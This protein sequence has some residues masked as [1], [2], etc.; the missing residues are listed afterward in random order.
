MSEQEY[1][2]R[3]NAILDDMSE[4]QREIEKITLDYVKTNGTIRNYSDLAQPYGF[5]KKLIGL[6]ILAA[7]VEDWLVGKNPYTD[8]KSRTKKVRKAFDY[9]IP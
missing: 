9:L 8:A 3:L 4:K 2:Q 7:M 6:A 5:D 1:A